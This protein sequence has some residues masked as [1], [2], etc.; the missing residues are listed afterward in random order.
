M[1][2]T[3]KLVPN[4]IVPKSI[5]VTCQMIHFTDLKDLYCVLYLLV[6]LKQYYTKPYHHSLLI[7]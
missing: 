6:Y 7:F 1:D 4:C 2:Q 5:A 3:S